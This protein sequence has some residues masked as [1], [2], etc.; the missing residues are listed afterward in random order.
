[1]MKELRWR[2]LG[3]ILALGLVSL[4]A[5][6]VYEGA[7][8]V[9]GAYL[10]L[11]GAPA[12][13]LGV[14]AAGEMV[15]VFS[16]M[17]GGY[18]AHRHPSP[19]LYWSILILGYSSVLSLPLLSMAGEWPQVI[20]L[21]YV[22]RFG[23]G[24][25]APVRDT[26]LS[27]VSEEVGRGK[28][29]GLHEL[30]DQVGAILGPLMVSS[31][32]FMGGE[33]VIESYRAAFASLIAP[34]I[35]SPIILLLAYRL[36]PTPRASLRIG[37]RPR[38]SG[39]FRGF[40]AFASLTGVGLIHWAIVSHYLQTQVGLRV[41]VPAEV[42]LIYL[43]A[44]MSDALLAI[45]LG[46]IYDRVGRK[47]LLIQPLTTLPITPLLFLHGGRAGLYAAAILWGLS[48]SSAETVMR[49]AVADY[50]PYR[51]RA[52]GYGLFSTSFHASMVLG[53]LIYSYLYQLNLTHL[54]IQVSIGFE[55]AALIL[56]I[57][58]VS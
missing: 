21:Y 39:G 9:G 18:V 38:I 1:M 22:E 5:D 45:P 33:Q 12:L 37:E 23:K 58:K 3:V 49:A 8:S 7:R 14:L 15:A 34:G 42:P 36:Y 35:L 17:V 56:G 40:L 28:G 32:I 19:R 26:V 53:A 24:V 47:T 25:R 10:N 52:F 55:I 29:F 13:V 43:V 51:S 54:I 20:L 30:L 6:M 11:L 46:A 4:F 50:L 16:R 44:M 48:M 41:L 27:E 2:L 31:V 57:R